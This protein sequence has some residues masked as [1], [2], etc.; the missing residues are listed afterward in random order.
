MDIFFKITAIVGA[1]AWLPQIVKEINYLI[2]KFKLTIILHGEI[3]VGYSVN[4]PILN[5]GTAL[6]AE[7]ADCLVTNIEI[8]VVGPNQD[9]HNFKW[10]WFEEKLYEIEY[11][12]IGTTPVKK[13]QTA[14]AIKILEENLVEKTI[15]Y[16]SP[17]FKNSYQQAYDNTNNQHELLVR[18]NN[19]VQ[20][21]R[22]TTEYDGF[23]NLLLNSLIWRQG[24]FSCK[25]RV[26][27]LNIKKT[28]DK[29]FKF[30]L[31]AN[32]I[33]K[34]QSNVD[35]CIKVLELHYFPTGEDYQANWNWINTNILD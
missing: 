19:D 21:L 13:Q 18:N 32:D 8:D 33:Q 17:I 7:N 25:M 30:R 4:G 20:T 34:L 23:R 1:C 11:T 2:T 12:E 14:I 29:E 6:S 26:T 16:H 28:F 9:Q 31:S 27:V 15:G 35:T 22:S 5:L 10:Q 24:V 3:Q